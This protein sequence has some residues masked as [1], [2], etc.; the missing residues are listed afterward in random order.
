MVMTTPDP[1]GKTS[2]PSD[3]TNTKTENRTQTE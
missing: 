1:A 3:G 2:G